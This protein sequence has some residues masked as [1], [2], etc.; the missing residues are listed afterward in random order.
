[1]GYGICSLEPGVHAGVADRMIYTYVYSC[2]GQTHCKKVLVVHQ[3]FTFYL[4]S[5]ICIFSLAT[6]RTYCSGQGG[7]KEHG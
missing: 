5:Q 1:M 7:L 3:K 2:L 6:L 4:V